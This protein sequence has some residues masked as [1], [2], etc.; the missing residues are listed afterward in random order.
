MLKQMFSQVE[1]VKSE[2]VGDEYH[3]RS[4]SISVEAGLRRRDP[5]YRIQSNHAK[6][7]A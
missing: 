5:W 7:G 2:Y 6:S 4:A 3:F 1:I